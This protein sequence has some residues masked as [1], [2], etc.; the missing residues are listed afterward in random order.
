MIR[1]HGDEGWDSKVGEDA[2]SE[3]PSSNAFD[4]I[5]KTNRSSERITKCT[6]V[7]PPE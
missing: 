2:V 4:A 6:I 5:V 3:C 7:N 1:D